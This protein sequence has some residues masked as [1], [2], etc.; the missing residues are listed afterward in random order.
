MKTNILKKCLVCK[1]MFRIYPY[2]EGKAKFCSPKCFHSINRPWKG[3]KRPEMSIWL[4]NAYKEGRKKSISLLGEKNPAW[5]GGLT[6]KLCLYCG[7]SFYVEPHRKSSARFC[8][9][10]CSTSTT[11]NNK[12]KFNGKKFDCLI[13]GKR[14]YRPRSLIKNSITKYCS[15]KCWGV[16]LANKYID[17]TKHPR[18]EG[19]KTPYLK[20]LRNSNSY[21]QWRDMVFK[22]DDYTCQIC[23][24]RGCKLQADHIKQFAYYPE[25]RFDTNNGRTLCE[26]C[27]KDTDTYLWKARVIHA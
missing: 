9:R 7:H 14:F 8:S 22:R 19:G 13:C 1:K 6:K 17:K 18:W 16:A 26:K 25:L 12:G 5:K 10:K 15:S 11:L 23:G 2:M 21:K 27:H 24:K 3:K 20:M 4:K